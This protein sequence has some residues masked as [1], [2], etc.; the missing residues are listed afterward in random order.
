MHD[1]FQSKLEVAKSKVERLADGCEQLGG[2]ECDLFYAAAT[3]RAR[4]LKVAGRAGAHPTWRPFVET[5]FMRGQRSRNVRP[6]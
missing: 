1:R 2:K 5:A 3:R 4:R 6:I